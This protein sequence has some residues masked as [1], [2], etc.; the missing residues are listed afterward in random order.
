[1]NIW[2][3]LILACIAGIVV[4]TVLKRRR[5]PSGCCGSCTGCEVCAACSMGQ[6]KNNHTDEKKTGLSQ[7][8]NKPEN[9]GISP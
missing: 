7:N 5:R 9:N 2:D 8:V 4:L 1:M 3:I 6:E